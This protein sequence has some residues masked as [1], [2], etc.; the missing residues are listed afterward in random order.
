[1]CIQNSNITPAASQHCTAYEILSVRNSLL[2]TDHNISCAA[3]NS[4]SNRWF[5][6]SLHIY[7]YNPL[8]LQCLHCPTQPPNLHLATSLI[9]TL[10]V[11]FT[12]QMSSPLS[13]TYVVPISRSP[14]S[15]WK[16]RK[17]IRSY[18]EL[19]AP[20]PTL[21]LEDHPLSAV[22]DCLFNIFAATLHIEG[23]SSN[24][25]IVYTCLLFGLR[26]LRDNVSSLYI[27]C[28]VLL[29][30]KQQFPAIG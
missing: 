17:M 12:F 20:C 7:W 23:R 22:R 21:K 14:R 26:P 13:T 19:L 29:D 24:R 9:C 5:L 8:P 1:M 4:V 2:L 16:I 18:G 25:I 28:Y 15:L 3:K 27:R 30:V 11:L 6:F 10:A